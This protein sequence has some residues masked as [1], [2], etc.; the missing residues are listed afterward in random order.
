MLQSADLVHADEIPVEG[1]TAGDIDLEHFGGFFEKQYGE[2]LGKMLDKAG[3]SLGQL[4]NNL[5]LAREATLNLAGLMIFGRQSSAASPRL[6]R[7]GCLLRRQRSCRRQVPGQPGHRRV[8]ARFAQGDD[9][10]SH[11][12]S[13]ATARRKRNQHGRRPGSAA[14][15]LGR[16]CRQHAAASG[17]LHFR[18]LAGVAVRQSHRADQP[19]GPAEQSNR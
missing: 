3:I 17:L 18:A 7:Q 4:L 16:T 14:G 12:Q 11:P 2:P 8:F 1:T 9:V 13:A 19:G 15:G 6:R 10:L 5:G